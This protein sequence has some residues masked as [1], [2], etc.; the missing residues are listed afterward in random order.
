MASYG[1]GF[2]QGFS[3]TF[4]ST[5][6]AV[7]K[8]NEMQQKKEK[9]LK[10]EAQRIEKEK[11]EQIS[12]VNSELT[13]TAYKLE[14]VRIEALDALITNGDISTYSNK[15]KFANSMVAMVNSKASGLSEQVG[16]QFDTSVVGGVLPVNIKEIENNFYDL[17]AIGGK[18]DDSKHI[19]KDGIIYEKQPSQ[20][21]VFNEDGNEIK[22]EQVAIPVA[23]PI[24]SKKQD[25]DS[26]M[27]SKGQDEYIIKNKDGNTI[28]KGVI[29]NAEAV[30]YTNKGFDVSKIDNT[31]D[32]TSIGEK[33][34]NIAVETGYNG[35][36]EQWKKEQQTSG[37]ISSTINAK[38]Y[39][40]KVLSG[41]E[42]FDLNKAIES[43]TIFEE[44]KGYNKEDVQDFEKSVRTI[45]AGDAL[46]ADIENKIKEGVFSNQW[47]DVPMEILTKAI[48]DI[49]D[50][51]DPKDREEAISRLETKGSISTSVANHLRDMSG[52]AASEAEALRTLK[53]MFSGGDLTSMDV[54]LKTYKRFI[55]DKKSTATSTAKTIASKG[56]LITA[57]K[58][59]DKDKVTYKDNNNKESKESNIKPSETYKEKVGNAMYSFRNM[60]G[61]TEVWNP[62]K[63]KWQ[64]Y[65]RG[66]N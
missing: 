50:I 11:K 63:K 22:Q 40:M 26:T 65:K 14:K 55:S 62:N 45:E 58:Y 54:K 66:T 53:S 46:I 38:T 57:Y 6:S 23:K 59:L 13:D 64:I 39:G 15:A 42:D 35:S 7:M 28:K 29:T 21:I 49:W 47:K 27:V 4:N 56:G 24:A 51:V 3:S 60:N 34:Y 48:P 36:Y 10:L 1:E 37:E 5:F 61:N 2:A 33:Q 8:Y 25:K 31:K 9:E 16:T 20:E 32:N 41:K 52:T 44:S 12:T 18:F 17:D 19:V 43:Q 30:A